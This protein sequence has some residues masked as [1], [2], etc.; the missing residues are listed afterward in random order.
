MEKRLVYRVPALS[1]VSSGRS[2]EVNVLHGQRLYRYTA[3]NPGLLGG[4]GGALYLL[5]HTVLCVASEI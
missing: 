2:V 3:V 1:L 5:L 4:D